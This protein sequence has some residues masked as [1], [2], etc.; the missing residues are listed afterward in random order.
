M[1]C[2][3]AAGGEARN[4]SASRIFD[5]DPA[6][7]PIDGRLQRRFTATCGSERHVE[8]RANPFFAL[9]HER[10]FAPPDSWVTR[11]GAHLGEACISST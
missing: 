1:F 5:A 6:R 3:K 9:S 11:M 2:G 4:Y 8:K 7:N 10:G